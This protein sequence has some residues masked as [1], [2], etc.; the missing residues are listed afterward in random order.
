MKVERIE[1]VV[2]EFCVT[3]SKLEAAMLYQV[4]CR[5]VV[6]PPEM[7]KMADISTRKTSK[8][9]NDLHSSLI[10]SGVPQDCGTARKYGEC[11]NA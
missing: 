7:L 2:P 8:F 11:D 3:L 4:S 10:N 9:L 1:P 5:T 6:L